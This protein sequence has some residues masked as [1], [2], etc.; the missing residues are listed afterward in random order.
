MKVYC[1]PKIKKSGI[2]PPLFMLGIAT[3]I[4]VILFWLSL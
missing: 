3:A 2:L 1:P 4:P